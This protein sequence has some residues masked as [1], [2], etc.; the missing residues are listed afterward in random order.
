MNAPTV[1]R[2]HDNPRDDQRSV[3]LAAARSYMEQGLVLTPNRAS[4]TKG[5]YLPGWSTRRLSLLQLAAELDRPGKG[6]GVVLGE[7]SG[8][9]VDVDL[10]HPAAVLAADA[11]LPPTGLV[12]GRTD[13]PRT[14]RFYR[15]TGAATAAYKTA[16]TGMLVELR[17]A[18]C[19]TV[20][21]P[22]PHPAG[23]YHWDSQGEPAVVDAALLG[24]LTGQVAAA[25]CLI[26]RGWVA[27]QALA[28]VRDPDLEQIAAWER[29]GDDWP[30]LRSW[31]SLDARS[32]ERARSGSRRAIDRS[33]TSPD[34]Q[35]VLDRVGGV[36]GA[37]R[38]LGLE[39]R[40]GHQA[41][42]WHDG[43]GTRSLQVTGA[44]WRCHAG[45]GQGNAIYLAA[46]VLGL[47]Y[48][49]ARDALAAR[50][51]IACEDGARPSGGGVKQTSRGRPAPAEDALNEASGGR[52]AEPSSVPDSAAVATSGVTQAAATSAE[53]PRVLEA[54]LL[55]A[56]LTYLSARGLPRPTGA[57]VIR[58]TGVSRARAYEVRKV[59]LAA[60]P[61]LLRPVGR[62]ARAPATA[63][64]STVAEIAGAVRDYLLEHPGAAQAG[65]QRRSYTDSFR[66]FVLELRE[67]YQDLEH[68]TFAKAAGVPSRTLS[69]W[70]RSELTD[71]GDEPTPSPPPAEPAR[72]QRIQTILAAWETWKGTFGAFCTHVEQHLRIPY[73][74]TLI[75][76]IL[77]E[78]GVRFPR[79]R[80]GRSP[81]ERALRKQFETF[82]P[83]A[84]WS[85]DGSQFSVDV[86]GERFTFNV[87]PTIDTASDA[88]IGL[89]IREQ[90]DAQAVVESFEDAVAE[91]GKPPLGHLLD[92]RPS[93]HTEEVDEALGETLRMRSTPGRAQN[94]AH[95]EGAF[96]LLAQTAPPLRV[97]SLRPVDVAFSVLAL[98]VTTWART[99]NHKPR[100]DR[101]GRTR[102]QL[103]READPTPE[104]VEQ[105]RRR[106]E[107][108]V[109]KQE[110]AR[111]TLEARQDPV[112]RKTLDDA[113]A[114]LGLDDP[115]GH[116]RAAIA[117][118]SLDH[119]VAGVAIFEGKRN[120]GTL[121]AGVDARYLLGIVRNVALQDEGV[122]I[123]EAL[124][125][126]RLEAGDQIL[127]ALDRER[128]E[129]ARAARD[130]LD[131]TGRLADRSMAATSTLD[132]S[133]WLRA[134][135]DAISAEPQQEHHA[136]F[137]N[138]VRRI[139]ATYCVSH[140]DRLA[141]VRR[142]AAMLRPLT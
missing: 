133:F 24:Q 48:L 29:S 55:L 15:A 8:W 129:E 50:L 25:A 19:Q 33:A 47:S 94:K 124:W 57:D 72:N 66:R 26:A 128:D 113:F 103:Y 7:P 132:R 123:A 80:S 27:E 131:L 23:S 104:E 119:V 76:R 32:R 121:P 49:E 12:S 58:E 142:L 140:S 69:D 35:A 64:P 110:Q 11:L 68:E 59:I 62:P 1:P 127:V 14:H 86:A 138:A 101:G 90:E 54:G 34:T 18:G 10:D 99:L 109:R 111:R 85:A 45:C 100:V 4:T 6:I 53:L 117:R 114:R 141:A 65:P 37:A 20:L 82:F 137:R 30:P 9:L 40:E 70:T 60:L 125:R 107:E 139:H 52:R 13:R 81:D 91:T 61:G 22:S 56:A 39:L 67:R 89:S 115:E 17:A 73:K 71:T 95:S 135:S 77:K 118:Y 96:G 84:Q 3:L 134:L 130:P 41:C 106:L 87:E 122:H 105:A 44:L 83:G 136:L 75:T 28:F 36:V 92:N 102:A 126:A 63:S 74:R 5:A 43:K 2:D 93:N 21:P 116:F 97:P 108:I 120:A 31:L 16:A 42:P 51:G 38:V 46:K 78:H 88:L 79:R 98:V 112:V